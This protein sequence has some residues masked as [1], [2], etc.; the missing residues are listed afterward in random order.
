MTA[1]DVGAVS[2]LSLVRSRPALI[3]TRHFAQRRGSHG[4]R[5]IYRAIE[6]RIDDE[7]SISHAVAAAIGVAS[8]VVHSGIEN[9]PLVPV[10]R[11]SRTALI[12]QRLQP[13]KR[14]DVGVRAFAASGLAAD[15]WMLTVAGSGAELNSLEQLARNLRVTDAVRFVGFRTD[16]RELMDDAGILIAPCDVEGLGLT[17]LEAMSCG[18]PVLAADAS[19]HKEVLAGLDGRALFAPDDV[20]AAGDNLRSLAADRAGRAALGRAARERQQ[21]EF[22]LSTQAEA[23]D[24]VYRAA[25]AARTKP[26]GKLTEGG[27]D[28]D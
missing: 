28:H 27:H 3:A 19:G 7:V 4:P 2:G 6:R 20:N 26:A 14:T 17:V 16:I 8:T 21:S 11:R 9:H 18:L 25:I 10:E 23:T 24:A 13:E 12:A 1:A 15:G 22:S 5:F